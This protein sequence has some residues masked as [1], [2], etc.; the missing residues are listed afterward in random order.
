MPTF[1]TG[2]DLAVTYIVSKILQRN[3]K[4]SGN[5]EPN[6][7][8]ANR[9]LNVDLFGNHENYTGDHSR[10]FYLYTKSNDHSIDQNRQIHCRLQVKLRSFQVTNLS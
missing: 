3:T 7:G 10:M 9:T 4:I 6:I 2:Q 8:R 1:L 5:C